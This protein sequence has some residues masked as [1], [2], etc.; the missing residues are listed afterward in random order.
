MRQCHSNEHIRIIK[1]LPDLD[2]SIEDD[3]LRK[4]RTTSNTN[5]YVN[6]IHC[7]IIPGMQQLNFKVGSKFT[8]R[9]QCGEVRHLDATKTNLM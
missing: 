6:I 1:Y 4:I 8:Q 9:L 5:R 3:G 7:L 2:I